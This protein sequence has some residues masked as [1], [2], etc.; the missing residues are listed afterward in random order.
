MGEARAA[1]G[2]SADVTPIWDEN[3]ANATLEDWNNYL[4]S[5]EFDEGP[6]KRGNKDLYS[7]SSTVNRVETLTEGFH[8]SKV[9]ENGTSSGIRINL[10]TG[11]TYTFCI[12]TSAHNST[13]SAPI[14]VYL[15]TGSD[16][17]LYEMSFSYFNEGWET[18]FDLS[19]VPPEWRGAFAWQPYRDVHSYE[20]LNEVTFSTSLDHL[21][22]RVAGSWAGDG[23]VVTDE[24]YLIV[25]AWDNGRDSDAPDP[26]VD[27]D[28]D[29]T[30]MT[31]EKVTLP[32][33]TVTLV[34]MAVMIS[35]LAVPLVV[36]RKYHNLGIADSGVDLVPAIN[37]EDK[38][39][40]KDYSV[41]E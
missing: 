36:H 29:I 6:G 26:N 27:V 21:E 39:N 15:I 4:F 16:W 5:E 35:L 7:S 37:N 3:V 19:D 34:C 17:D 13:I 2:C 9:V 11:Y 25:D 22:T 24:F 41:L 33:W 20:N 10:T 14:D 40:Q 23:Y 12:T 30:I 8:V 18:D 1:N 32:T 28:L 38:S 31:E